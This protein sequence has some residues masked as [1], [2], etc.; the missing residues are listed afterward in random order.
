MV[1]YTDRLPTEFGVVLVTDA[2][3]RNKEVQN[4]KAFI[5]W[6]SRHAEV[7]I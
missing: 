1:T 4:T 7:L 6:S 3:R 5:D 2:I